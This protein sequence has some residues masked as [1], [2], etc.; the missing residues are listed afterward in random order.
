MVDWKDE[1]EISW[2]NGFEAGY[3]LGTCQGATEKYMNAVRWH[4]GEPK[5]D[6]RHCIIVLKGG[7]RVK[8]VCA[9]SYDER[10]RLFVADDPDVWDGSNHFTADAV[11]L[12]G[13]FDLPKVVVPEV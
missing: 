11:A 6:L 8:K 7:G 2:N 9:A 13:T 1:T 12:Y 4:R 3:V 5:T 10:R